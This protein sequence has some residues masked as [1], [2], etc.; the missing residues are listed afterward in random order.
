MLKVSKLQLVQGLMATESDLRFSFSSARK[1]S[2]IVVF[3]C[4]LAL[5]FAAEPP[6]NNRLPSGSTKSLPTALAVL[7]FA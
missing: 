3:Y 2:L 1:I 4:P 7:S 6:R 5:M